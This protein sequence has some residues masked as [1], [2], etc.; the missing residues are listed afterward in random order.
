MYDTIVVPVDGS[1]PAHAAVETA[2]QVAETFDAEVSF[3]AV[4]EPS[5]RSLTEPLPD[6]PDRGDLDSQWLEAFDRAE[7]RAAISGVPFQT[8]FESGAPHEELESHA[9]SVDADLVTMGTHGRTGLDRLL[10]GSVTERT[11]RVLDVPVLTVPGTDGFVDDVDDVLVPTDGS[12]GSERAATQACAFADAHDA[13]VHALGVVD[14]QSLA[15]VG[16]GGVAIPDVIHSLEA[17]RERDVD[18]VRERAEDY[19]VDVDSTVTEGAPERVIRDAA[20]DRDADLIAM[21]THGRQGVERFF[22]GSVTERTVREGEVP[23]L[24]TPLEE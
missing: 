14:V 13:T 11:L 10:L 6:D 15:A 17:Q 12:P 7:A 4:V 21:G 2:V 9:E 19:G 22:L 1:D 23:V 20:D 24:A 16:E 5:E 8:S 18:A 3:L